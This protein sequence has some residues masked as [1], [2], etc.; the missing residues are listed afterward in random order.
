M[1][2]FLIQKC[3]FQ[4]Q[5][6]HKISQ[7]SYF[8]HSRYGFHHCAFPAKVT[9]VILEHF[10]ILFV[11]FVGLILCVCDEW[12]HGEKTASQNNTRHWEQFSPPEVDGTHTDFT[13]ALKRMKKTGRAYE[14][15]LSR[16][17]GKGLL[18]L[19]CCLSHM[20]ILSP[21]CSLKTELKSQTFTSRF[22][23]LR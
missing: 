5:I 22:G 17:G 1:Q 2:G 6:S 19:S 4:T 15:L 11:I 16:F 23:S 13:V 7:K 9:L 10:V 12:S 8:V 20:F 14:G 21:V 18:F 3:D